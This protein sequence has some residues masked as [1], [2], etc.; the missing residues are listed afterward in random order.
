[1]L[2]PN[3][4]KKVRMALPNIPGLHDP[5][6]IDAAL[7]RLE[8]EASPPVVFRM[9][10]GDDTGAAIYEIGRGNDVRT[11]TSRKRGVFALWRLLDSGEPLD[12][13]EVARP[14]ARRPAAT[15]YQAIKGEA[16]DEFKR[17]GMPELVT[18]SAW[19]C[20]RRGL[21]VLH[22]PYSAPTFITGEK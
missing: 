14:D 10:D 20:T 7:R 3:D 11:V 5:V 4:W 15:V 19:C 16:C 21:L 2:S 13:V 17:W 22:L 8:V 1:M 12:P 9:L 18:A 6:A